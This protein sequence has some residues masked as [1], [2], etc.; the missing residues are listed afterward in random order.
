M[1]GSSG[2]CLSGCWGDDKDLGMVGRVGAPIEVTVTVTVT[3][4]TGWEYCEYVKLINPSRSGYYSDTSKD[5][6]VEKSKS[7]YR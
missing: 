1:T 6:R 7:R 5:Q 2:D 3:I 4:T